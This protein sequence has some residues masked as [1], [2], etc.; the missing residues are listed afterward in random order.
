[1]IAV[2]SL[3]SR[4]SDFFSPIGFLA[5]EAWINRR[6]PDPETRSPRPV[7]SSQRGWSAA[8]SRRGSADSDRSGC[9][10]VWQQWRRRR[11]W[12]A[13]RVW[14][15]GAEGERQ[16]RFLWPWNFRV[17]DPICF[18]QRVRPPLFQRVQPQREA[19]D[20]CRG[21]LPECL[22]RYVTDLSDFRLKKISFFKF[23]YFLI[24]FSVSNVRLLELPETGTAGAVSFFSTKNMLFEKSSGFFNIFSF[25]PGN[26]GCSCCWSDGVK[27]FF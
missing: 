20:D 12:G 26:G 15:V 21:K 3:R 16:S 19:H 14:P 1:M 22:S 27:W 24:F 8:S 4:D 13:G 9:H 7:A 25:F 6:R 2:Q 11:G 10:G 17:F 5:S 18:R 23:Q